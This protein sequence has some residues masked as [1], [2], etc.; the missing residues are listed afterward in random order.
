VDFTSSITLQFNDLFSPGF[1]QARRSV[2]DLKT[3]LDGI[4]AAGLDGVVPKSLPQPDI[5]QPVIPPP[6][7]PNTDIPQPMVPQPVIPAPAVPESTIPAPVIPESRIPRQRRTPKSEAPPPPPTPYDAGLKQIQSGLDKIQ[8]NSALNTV[9]AQLSVMANMTAPLRNSLAGMMNEPSR[10]AGTF[11]SSMKNIQSLTNESNKSLAVLSKELLEIGSAAVAGPNAVADAYYNI[12]SGI[13]DASVRLDALRAAV[14]LAESGQTDLGAATNGLINVVNAYGTSAE[15]MAAMSDVFFQTVRKGKGSLGGFV[16]SLS[17]VSGLS[18]QVGIGFDELGATMA[19]MTTGF[20]PSESVAATQIKAAIT[21]LLKPNAELQ[22]ALQAMGGISGS[23]MLKEYGLAASL[24]MVK[25]ALGGSQ[26][27]MADALGSTEALNAAIALTTDGYNTFAGSYSAGISGATADALIAQA[28]SYES[29]LAKLQAASSALKITTGQDINVIKG[30]FV[31]MGAGFLTHVVNPIASS[32][33]GGVFRGIAAFAG[34]GAQGLLSLGSGALNTAAQLSVLAANVKNFDGYKEMFRGALS[35]MGAPLKTLG[36]SIAHMAGTLA[37]HISTMIVQTATTFT[38]T[39][40]TS[41]Y[42][43]AMWAAAGATWAAVAPVLAVVGVIAAVVGAVALVAFGVYQLI[44]NWSAVSSFF[45]G[46][47]NK[48]TNIF[49]IAAAWLKAFF[50]SL[51]GSLWNNVLKEPVTA[52]VNWIG[53]IWSVVVSA[54]TQA[55]GYVTGFFSSIWDGI[56]TK[57]LIIADWF[58][59]VWAGIT[60]GFSEAWTFIGDLFASIWEGIKGVV[61]GFIDWLSPIIDVILA[62]F[63]GIGAVIGGIISTVGGWFGKA[64]DAGNTAAAVQKSANALGLSKDAAA[65][66]NQTVA[67]TVTL[68]T[69]D[70]IPPPPETVT[71]AAAAPSFGEPIVP[72]SAFTGTAAADLLPEFSSAASVSAADS[73]LAPAPGGAPVSQTFSSFAAPPR[74][75]APELTYTASS[76]F[77]DALSGAVIPDLDMSALERRVEISLREIAVPQAPASAAPAQK[78]AAKQ[79]RNFGPHNI[80]IQKLIVQAEEFK[81]AYDMLNEIIHLVYEPEEAPV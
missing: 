34:L 19:Y 67:G 51:W 38:A 30:F 8:Q 78:D 15:N 47:W 21:S 58:G 33:V 12:T 70:I 79:T 26:D 61:V 56:V 53:G 62:P 57:V 43:A 29:K 32:P 54:F 2:I 64:V 13:G 25:D 40:A 77:S 60:G 6:A 18:A 42:A 4:G 71:S 5:P 72:P 68:G 23:A 35:V 24:Q 55:W 66:L 48:I 44:K 27:K 75:S 16:S 22:K 37:A 9:A 3:S 14:N 52:F 31:D 50:G 41:G 28:Q 1:A 20:S 11:E 74:A 76:A 45:A 69:A 63:R 17:S 65:E 49:S 59:G 36:S 46:L 81:D 80:T 73:S 10:L 7:V 39:A